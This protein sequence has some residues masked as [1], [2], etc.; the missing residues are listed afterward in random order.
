MIF[1]HKD[2]QEFN[3]LCAK[4]LKKN[5]HFHFISLLDIN[6]LRASDAYMRQ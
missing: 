6:S 2:L 1:T 3:S 4:L 5:K